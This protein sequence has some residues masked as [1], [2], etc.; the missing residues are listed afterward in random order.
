MYWLEVSV[1]TDGE[2]AEAVAEHLFPFAYREGVVFE[3]KGDATSLDPDALE[4]EV[5]VKIYLPGEQDTPELRLKI[6]TTLYYLNRLY[7]AIPPP[8]F[9][10][11]EEEDWANAWRK[12]YTPFRIGRRIW[13]Q[14]SWLPMENRDVDDIILTL[15]PGMAFGTGLHPS[16]QM[17]LQA[18]EQYL[19]PGMKVLDVGTGSGILSIAATKLGASHVLAFDVDRLAVLATRQNALA[20]HSEHQLDIFQG[21]LSAL[22]ILGWDIVLVNILAPIIVELLSEGKLLEYLNQDG[23]LIL[24]GIIEEQKADVMNALGDVGGVVVNELIVGDW[25]CLISQKQTTP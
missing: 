17:C 25:V 10:R 2:A 23:I 16:T 3:Q 8:K 21:T 6:E 9:V 18:L 22:A 13:I 20:N 14:P 12:N 7:S 15:D 1:T 24:S 5:S 4:P 11:L 19:G